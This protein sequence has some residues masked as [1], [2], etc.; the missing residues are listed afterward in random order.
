MTLA[1]TPDAGR[2]HPL[3]LP[4]YRAPLPA[5]LRRFFVKYA[6]FSGRAGRAEY[7]WAALLLFVMP[8]VVQV[9]TGVLTGDW[10]TVEGTSFSSG[11]DAVLLLFYIAT[12]VPTLAVGWRRMHDINRTGLWT[13]IL[14]VP[15]VGWLVF[16]VFALTG[17]RPEGARFD[18]A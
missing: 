16:I 18:R 17:P 11:P 10:S 3:H 12:T 1:S 14:L 6:T 4:Y 5:A 8:Y 9:I 7:W 15:L 2:D 13:L